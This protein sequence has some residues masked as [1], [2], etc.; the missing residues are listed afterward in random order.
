MSRKHGAGHFQIGRAYAYRDR[1]DPAF[2]AVLDAVKAV[3]D[4]KGLF[5]H[6]GPNFPQGKIAGLA[7]VTSL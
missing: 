6:G 2:L 3:V 1:R 7:S 5:N 4:P